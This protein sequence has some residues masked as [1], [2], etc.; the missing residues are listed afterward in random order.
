METAEK[1]LRLEEASAPSPWPHSELSQL[2][3]RR[4]RSLADEQKTQ[5]ECILASKRAKQDE[6]NEV[7][8]REGRKERKT[9]QEV[10]E[11]A[12][13]TAALKRE[14]RTPEECDAQD[15]SASKRVREPP[16]MCEERKFDEFLF[17]R[18]DP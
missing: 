15:A 5:A 18:L 7:V 14:C 3:R 13:D 11:E 8:E 2:P 6:L 17:W 16:K 10:K 12:V 9:Q 1:R 4:S